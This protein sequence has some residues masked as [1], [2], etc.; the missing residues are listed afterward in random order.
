MAYWIH[1]N[2]REIFKKNTKLGDIAEPDKV[3]ATADNNK[4]LRL[5]YEVEIINIGFNC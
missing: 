5:W 3:L 4:F 1:E 2:A